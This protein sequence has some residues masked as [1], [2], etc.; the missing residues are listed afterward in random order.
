M[1]V[2]FLYTGGAL[3]TA[4]DLPADVQTPRVRVIQRPF[5][6]TF[7]PRASS[8]QFTV[9]TYIYISLPPTLQRLCRR[10]MPVC[11]G[12]P[13]IQPSPL[14]LRSGGSPKSHHHVTVSHNR[15]QLLR[16]EDARAPIREAGSQAARSLYEAI[17]LASSVMIFAWLA[18]Q[19]PA[20]R[21]GLH[22][23]RRAQI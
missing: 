20:P 21:W 1:L 2:P 22:G 10:N 23:N 7:R 5:K 18:S 11:V 19:P 13:L 15:P 14:V 16:A 8:S 9:K 6:R 12:E 3:P 4:A 17:C